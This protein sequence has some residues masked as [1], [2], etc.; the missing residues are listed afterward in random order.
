MRY[1]FLFSSVWCTFFE[2]LFH[3]SKKE[4]HRL[5]DLTKPIRKTTVRDDLPPLN[6]DDEESWDSNVDDDDL[7]SL[8]DDEGSLGDMSDASDDSNEE[9]PYET[10]P[11]IQ[12]TTVKTPDE[13]KRLP[14]KL[15]NGKIQETGIKTMISRHPSLSEEPEDISE[16]EAE[17]EPQRVE[18]VST[19]ARFG[20]PA[21]V[22]VLQTK[23]RKHRVELAKEQIAGICQDILADPENGVSLGFPNPVF[24]AR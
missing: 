6:S 12:P 23:S 9:M 24:T 22:D 15:A 1:S 17:E 21:V 13:I 2:G 18:D 14:I 4:T 8:D 11:R 20:R 5:H 19:G 3:R 16:S 10:I 7:E